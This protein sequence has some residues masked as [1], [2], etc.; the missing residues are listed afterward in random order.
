M[1]DIL[2]VEKRRSLAKPVSRLLKT[3][4]HAVV[5]SGYGRALQELTRGGFAAVALDWPAQEP[6]ARK[7]ARTASDAGVPVL[8]ITNR[9]VKCVHS[10]RHLVR[11]FLEKPAT[12]QEIAEVMCEMVAAARLPGGKE[13]SA[14]TAGEK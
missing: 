3:A 14:A 7:L 2:F 1:A 11:V 4:G 9:L 5:A 13:A 12:P 6:R 10:G 8:A